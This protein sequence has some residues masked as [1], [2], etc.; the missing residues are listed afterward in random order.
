MS[1]KTATPVR[2]PRR[3]A[4]RPDALNLARMSAD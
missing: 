1:R 3:Y 4:S 2:S